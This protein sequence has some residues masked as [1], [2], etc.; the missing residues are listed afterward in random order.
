MVR[1]IKLSEQACTRIYLFDIKAQ[2]HGWE[3]DRGT[4]DG[5]A[6]AAYEKAK[7]RLELYVARLER[8]LGTIG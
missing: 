3:S 5:P 2:H 6:K 4:R 7:R 1:K 8:E